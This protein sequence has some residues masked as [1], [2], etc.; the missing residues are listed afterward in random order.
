MK[1]S[2]S[3][4][5][6][7]AYNKRKNYPAHISQLQPIQIENSPIP[8]SYPRFHFNFEK[9]SEFIPIPEI[10]LALDQILSHSPVELVT[11]IQ[12]GWDCAIK[13]DKDMANLT[14]SIHEGGFTCDQNAESFKQFL[15]TNN[16]LEIS[17]LHETIKII[18]PGG[19]VLEASHYLRVVATSSRKLGVH[20]S[21]YS[22]M[23]NLRGDNHVRKIADTATAIIEN[24][25]SRYTSFIFFNTRFYEQGVRERGNQ[26]M[27]ILSLPTQTTSDIA[28]S[29]VK[30]DP[31]QF[32]TLLMS[33]L[34]QRYSSTNPMIDTT[35]L[36]RLWN[37]SDFKQ[38]DHIK[39]HLFV[40][41]PI[42]PEHND[43]NLFW[44]SPAE[45]EII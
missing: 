21:N 1:D 24:Q 26:G 6:K 25:A 42:T 43:K 29:A 7:L 19:G 2:L 12:Q 8:I 31:V 16:L 20:P 17:N 13:S 10:E 34:V 9:T 32:M 15:R 14:L 28:I 41:R 18:E 35:G 27:L 44:D 5:H 39:H 23:D 4:I 22:L 37:S 38:D 36:K 30:K 11:S 40:H 3:S 45:I 33:K